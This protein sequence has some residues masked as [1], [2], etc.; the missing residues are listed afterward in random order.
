MS[1]IVDLSA[2]DFNNQEIAYRCVR[3]RGV[4][5][6]TIAVQVRFMVDPRIKHYVESDLFETENYFC[7]A[8]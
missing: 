7:L 5:N 8:S 4:K 2:L 3:Q 6:P 1:P